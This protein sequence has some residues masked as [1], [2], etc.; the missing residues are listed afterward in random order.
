L[1]RHIAGLTVYK[2]IRVN[3]PGVSGV[4]GG[5]SYHY[6]VNIPPEI[7][8]VVPEDT[9]FAP[10][11]TEEGILLRRIMATSELPSWATESNGG[12]A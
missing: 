2:L 7:G 1:T 6:R 8:D 4:Q 12:A 10:E 11:L 5:T 9:Y 3:R